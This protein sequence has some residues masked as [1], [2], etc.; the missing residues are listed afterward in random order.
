MPIA[1]G[2]SGWLPQVDSTRR[3][4]DGSSVRLAGVSGSDF[5][6]RNSALCS[7]ERG[8]LEFA[9]DLGEGDVSAQAAVRANR[10]R[11]ER[12]G[13]FMT[14]FLTGRL[15]ASCQGLL[16]ARAGFSPARRGK[17]AGAG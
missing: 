12:T 14:G 6:L 4:S 1:A 10:T 7:A 3:D 9:T 17:V 11:D 8:G 13:V 15:H 5:S 2:S 16:T